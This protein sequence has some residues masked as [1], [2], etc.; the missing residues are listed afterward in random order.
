MERISLFLRTNETPSAINE[1]MFL[2]VLRS[3]TNDGI[4]RL[5]M[6]TMNAENQYV[7]ASMARAMSMARVLVDPLIR[8][9][10]VSPERSG[11]PKNDATVDS[12][13]NSAAAT[14][15]MPY[16]DT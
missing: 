9:V 11:T 8:A 14:G 3:P 15:T 7:P 5:E 6:K 2:V 1:K 16:T 4:S 10:L 13:A 12:S